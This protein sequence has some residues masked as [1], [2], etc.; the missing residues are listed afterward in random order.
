[1]LNW[2]WNAYVVTE[3]NYTITLAF[4]HGCWASIRFLHANI[5]ELEEVING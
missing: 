4:C 3:P 2:G 5:A 1:M